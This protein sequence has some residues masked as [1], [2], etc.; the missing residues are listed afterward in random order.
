MDIYNLIIGILMFIIGIF[1]IIL[2]NKTTR[3]NNNS[4]NIFKIYVGGFLATFL[5]IVMVV[6][7]IIKIV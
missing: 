1:G 4:G 2:A 6:N 7:E 5:G 3:T